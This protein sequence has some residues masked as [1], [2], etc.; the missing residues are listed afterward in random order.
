MD[1]SWHGM[2]GAANAAQYHSGRKAAGPVMPGNL[3]LP[4][5]NSYRSIFRHADGSHDWKT[6]LDCKRFADPT[7]KLDVK[8]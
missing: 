4:A 6:E 8:S 2:T 1:A 3:M 7:E 5:P